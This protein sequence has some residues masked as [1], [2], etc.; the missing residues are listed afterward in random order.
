MPHLA[1]GVGG[2]PARER[3]Y[4]RG[5]RHQQGNVVATFHEERDRGLRSGQGL[6]RVATVVTGEQGEFHWH[7]GAVLPG[8][9]RAIAESLL[10][11]GVGDACAVPVRAGLVGRKGEFVVVRSALL[12]QR[13]EQVGVTGAKGG[14][15]VG[16]I[17]GVERGGPG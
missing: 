15:R 8:G 11:L 17:G 14:L 9:H 5:E 10:P 16:A 3:S 6:G 12:A 13:L 1:L 2:T 4:C 7:V